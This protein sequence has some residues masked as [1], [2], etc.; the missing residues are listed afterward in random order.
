MIAQKRSMFLDEESVEVVKDNELI[1]IKE[2]SLDIKRTTVTKKFE[3]TRKPK[4]GY[5]CLFEEEIHESAQAVAASTD[6]GNK[7]TSS[8][9]VICGGLAAE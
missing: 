9:T 1:E 7:F 3:V 8:S 5:S 2:G 4:P 6:H